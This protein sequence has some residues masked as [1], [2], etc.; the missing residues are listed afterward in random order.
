MS[1]Y[2]WLNSAQTII[3]AVVAV[4][5]FVLRKSFLA[6]SSW[7]D[8]ERGNTLLSKLSSEV[9]GMPERCRKVAEAEVKQQFD[10]VIKPW[11]ERGDRD[12][13]DIWHRISTRAPRTRD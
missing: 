1:I 8:F 4:L 9:Q 13:A 6:G 10:E 5:V 7:R 3:L 11:L 12:R 2:E